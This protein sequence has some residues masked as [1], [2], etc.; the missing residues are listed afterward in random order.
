[1]WL[2][3]RYDSSNEEVV[4]SEHDV[5]GPAATG[6]SVVSISTN[7]RATVLRVGKT[8]RSLVEASKT[9]AKKQPQTKVRLRIIEIDRMKMF[10][11][12]SAL[13]LLST[14]NAPVPLLSLQSLP[15]L[16]SFLGIQTRTP[17]PLFHLQ[18]PLVE[19]SLAPA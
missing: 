9:P 7:K 17:L 5:K 4:V 19:K 6:A 2:R 15:P 11:L 18:P 16:K 13:L 8:K 3:I 10:S 1:M 12:F 14:A